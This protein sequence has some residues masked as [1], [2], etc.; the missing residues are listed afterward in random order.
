LAGAVKASIENMFGQEVLGLLLTPK[1]EEHMVMAVDHVW[2]RD[3]HERF[4]RLAQSFPKLLSDEE[5][6]A[7]RIVQEEPKYWKQVPLESSGGRKSEREYLRKIDL[8]KLA[9]DWNKLKAQAGIQS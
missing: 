4:A 8:E 5:T 1:G 2:S 9:A 3:E 7:W 6:Y